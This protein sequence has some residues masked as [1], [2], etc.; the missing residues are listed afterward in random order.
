MTAANN[1]FSGAELDEAAP[2]VKHHN[3]VPPLSDAK[4]TP[5]SNKSQ[6]RWSF[7]VISIVVLTI[8][9]AYTTKRFLAPA[10]APLA[11]EELSLGDIATERLPTASPLA[12]PLEFSPS[13]TPAAVP[14]TIGTVSTSTAS[15]IVTNPAASSTT[16]NASPDQTAIHTSI[17]RLT[18]DFN[19]VSARIGHLESELASVKT[20]LAEQHAKA[21]VVPKYVTRPRSSTKAKPIITEKPTAPTIGVLSVDTWDGRPSVS[22]SQGQE[23]RFIGEGDA[24]AN[25]YVLKQADSK[26]QQAVFVAPSGET[27]GTQSPVNKSQ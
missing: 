10:P 7:V 8:G 24:V 14:S 21:A 2:T 22:V 26:K 9:G 17:D 12:R 25:G 20:T 5:K 6:A 11:A 23:I 3:R 15:P 19:S 27:H 13:L 16:V 4:T 18:R 1:R